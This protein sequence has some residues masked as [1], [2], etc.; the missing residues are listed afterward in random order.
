MVKWPPTRGWKGHIESPGR[1]DSKLRKSQFSGVQEWNLPREIIIFAPFFMA[2]TTESWPDPLFENCLRRQWI[3]S[4]DRWFVVP[5]HSFFLRIFSASSS[6]GCT[7]WN[8]KKIFS[9]YQYKWGK[10]GGFLKKSL[11]QK[12]PLALAMIQVFRKKMT[13]GGFSNRQRTIWAFYTNMFYCYMRL[14]MPWMM[15]KDILYMMWSPHHQSPKSHQSNNKNNNVAPPS[16]PPSP[17][18]LG[19]QLFTGAIGASATKTI[20]SPS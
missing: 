3:P 9:N 7:S 18:Q 19:I 6:S 8:W 11:K 15:Y 13:M 14:Y 16:L 10:I 17:E 4:T 12:T 1:R 2:N 20:R 5:G